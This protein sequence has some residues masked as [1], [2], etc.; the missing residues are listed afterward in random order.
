MTFNLAEHWVEGLAFLL[1]IVGLIL[2]L[3]SGSAVISY[4]ISFFCGAIGGR[5]W[6]KVNKDTKNV[7]GLML[8]GFLI[9][10]VIGSVYGDRGI[11]ILCYIAGFWVAYYL[12]K[13]GHVASVN[14]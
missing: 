11:V 13:K 7:W 9:G 4:A 8:L 3:F 10:L 5:I 14:Y 12:H 6:S 2:A 1:M